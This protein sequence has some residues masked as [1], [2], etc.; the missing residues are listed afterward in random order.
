VIW[1]AKAGFSHSS[2]LVMNG[3][4]YCLVPE[5][6]AYDAR[7]GQVLW[8]QPSLD[9]PNSSF[10]KW[11]SGGKDYLVVPIETAP[12]CIS[13]LDPANGKT[14]WGIAPASYSSPVMAGPDTL[15]MECGAMRAYRI[16]PNKAEMLWEQNKNCGARGAS[17]VVFQGHIYKAGASHNG[18]SLFCFDVK[19]G[20]INWSQVISSGDASSPVLADG[21]IF[22]LLDDGGDNV[23]HLLMVMYR[24]T[25]EKYEEL[26]RFHPDAGAS[27]SPA[28]VG[29]KLYLR[30]HNCIAC[31]D[32]RA[33]AK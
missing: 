16:T 4:V 22:A 23:D 26:G 6:T 12:R 11:T 7:T 18:K 8:R 21:K 31:Y 29:G 28:I 27:A 5:A 17:P 33:D 30:L 20:E 9:H 15:V 25:P 2:P 10:M 3:A 13:C 32:L 19:T 14:L 1:Q 24:A